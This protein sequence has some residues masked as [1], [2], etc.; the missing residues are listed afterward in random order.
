MNT[1]IY[2][3]LICI[4]V[5]P[6]V[7]TGNSWADETK[8]IIVNPEKKKLVG[9]KLQ[10]IPAVGAKPFTHHIDFT[11]YKQKGD[12][13]SLSVRTDD[14]DNGAVHIK[15]L[16]PG[17]Y[18]V[19]AE[20]EKAWPSGKVKSGTYVKVRKGKLAY[21]IFNMNLGKVTVRNK[22][23][24]SEDS[25][26]AN[27]VDVTMYNSS[28]KEV[29]EFTGESQSIWVRPGQYE[30]IAKFGAKHGKSTGLFSIKA[31]D[32]I[33]KVFTFNMALFKLK[34]T[35]NN[36]G[37][38]LEDVLYRIYTIADN[39]KG[40]QVWGCAEEIRGPRTGCWADS[41]S[42]GSKT[43]GLVIHP[44]KYML[45]AEHNNGALMKIN[46]EIKKNET[47]AHI[48]KFSLGT[49]TSTLPIDHAGYIYSKNEKNRSNYY[50]V[51]S[52][53]S[54]IIL[55]EPGDYRI[56]VKDSRKNL[57]I[58]TKEFKISKNKTTSLGL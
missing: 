26:L 2:R 48:F 25:S 18:Y 54:R 46:V 15:N 45:T 50:T 41:S 7:G 32:N 49:L 56:V 19:V 31:N 37:E 21:Y 11:V 1:T 58:K 22:V 53:Y 55:L 36:T 40:S 24:D 51:I 12:K 57:V 10:I 4:L 47:K 14:L 33:L 13:R 5:F 6:L 20:Y 9:L 23:S 52:S 8:P 27:V 29:G 17:S 39:K 28:S 38:L 43:G 34:A 42:L 35:K 16:E 44:G 3:A 30:I